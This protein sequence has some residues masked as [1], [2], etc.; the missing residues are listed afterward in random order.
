MDSRD[1]G[2][3]NSRSGK[4]RGKAYP[5]TPWFLAEVLGI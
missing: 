1:L 3:G 4:Q 2:G 5:M